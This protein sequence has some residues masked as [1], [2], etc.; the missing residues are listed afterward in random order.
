MQAFSL[1]VD[2]R[3][4]GSTVHIVMNARDINGVSSIIYHWQG[5]DA[6]GV[7]TSLAM[8]AHSAN[9]RAYGVWGEGGWNTVH[10]SLRAAAIIADGFGMTKRITSDAVFVNVSTAGQITVSSSGR[11]LSVSIDALQDGNDAAGRSGAFSYQWF[12]NNNSGGQRKTGATNARY[13]L[14]AEDVTA[15]NNGQ[16]PFVQVRYVDALGFVSNHTA[17]IESIL[18]QAEITRGSG[19]L[20]AMLADAANMANKDSIK[21]QWFNSALPDSGFAPIANATLASYSPGAENTRHYVRVSISYAFVGLAAPRVGLL[22]PSESILS[23]GGASRVGLQ[24]D[25]LISGS[26]Y[27]ADISNLRSL[28][29]SAVQNAIY[30]WQR[31]SSDGGPWESIISGVNLAVYSIAGSVVTNGKLVRASHFNANTTFFRVRVAD[32]RLAGASSTV[33]ATS[34]AVSLDRPP[35]GT[36]AITINTKTNHPNPLARDNPW[37]IGSVQA[38]NPNFQLVYRGISDLNDRTTNPELFRNYNIRYLADDGSGN[39]T[40]TLATENNLPSERIIPIVSQRG[41]KPIMVQAQQSER[42]T[43]RLQAVRYDEFG[44]TSTHTAEV[45]YVQYSSAGSLSLTMPDRM[46]VG[47][48]LTA[49]ALSITDRNGPEEPRVVL[50]WHGVRGSG[51]GYDVITNTLLITTAG[52]NA[53]G[54]LHLTNSVWNTVHVSARAV[55]RVFDSLGAETRITSSLVAINAPVVRSSFRVRLSTTGGETKFVV[56]NPG[57]DANNKTAAV[58]RNVSYIYYF[59]G[60]R[61]QAS[62]HPTLFPINADGTVLESQFKVDGVP[63]FHKKYREGTKLSVEVFYT[64]ELGFGESYTLENEQAFRLGNSRFSPVQYHEL[65]VEQNRLLYTVVFNAALEQG[66]VLSW[67]RAGQNGVL[68]T[69]NILPLVAGVTSFFLP[70]NGFVD[71]NV[72]HPYA[73][74]SLGY[75]F[76]GKQLTL[77]TSLVRVVEPFISG[78]MGMSGSAISVSAVYAADVS[79][80][81]EHIRSH[82]SSQRQLQAAAVD[83]Q[84]QSGMVGGEWRDIAGATGS[85]Y[86][87]GKHFDNAHPYLRALAINGTQTI[88]VTQ[89]VDVRSETTGDLR[90]SALTARIGGE[91]RGFISRNRLASSPYWAVTNRIKDANG[92]GRFAFQ[93]YVYRPGLAPLP[94]LVRTGQN[95]R[96]HP[97][98]GE[99][100]GSVATLQV[101]AVYTDALGFDST[102]TSNSARGAVAAAR[103]GG[104]FGLGV[105]RWF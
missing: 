102:V 84:W 48:I 37:W 25:G 6:A 64:D 99:L 39:F 103:N 7:A 12:A 87:L 53:N 38:D 40:I 88:T 101:R 26:Q 63:L 90:V 17:R 5:I 30:E 67:Q 70:R 52:G 9:G 68:E 82:P 43:V 23:F 41:Y 16:A 58:F 92:S 49:H 104:H 44:F 18:P 19:Q 47:A 50:E 24:G 57:T 3:R 45:V 51:S 89:P 91:G 96:Y 76:R 83:Y 59:D 98:L 14:I 13:I 97:R 75:V 33:W 81:F 77:T 8:P 31:G 69:L 27:T 54:G 74:V 100:P 73:K 46:T 15:I 71:F 4:V 62:T 105:Y 1:A 11:Q 61:Y 55:A 80:L 79:G 86:T 21:Y 10:V 56:S 22:S 34:H 72:R 36:I 29:G 85:R 94:L 60:V 66:S 32:G 28:N 78:T 65:K 20:L 35:T 93:W 95:R 2:S 42:T